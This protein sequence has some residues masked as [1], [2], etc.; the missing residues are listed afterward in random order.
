VF[1]SRGGVPNQSTG[2]INYGTHL[3]P[4][5]LHCIL[6]AGVRL[7]FSWAKLL[8]SPYNH[9]ES[10]E[11]KGPS[12]GGGGTGGFAF[13]DKSKDSALLQLA[14]AGSAEVGGIVQL[15]NL[16]SMQG[17]FGYGA[18]WWQ[19]GPPATL[20]DFLLQPHPASL[21]AAPEKV[22]WLGDRPGLGAKWQTVLSNYPISSCWGHVPS[23]FSAFGPAT[24]R[25]A[26][27]PG[28]PPEMSLF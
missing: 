10:Y 24:A 18:I 25:G 13:G 1:A 4:M 9:P 23:E 6:D 27:A 19:T 22:S 17:P 20:P 11:Y 7:Q 14:F 8:S 2:D 28:L 5:Q 3:T 12:V 16:Q 26:T 21:E 15:E